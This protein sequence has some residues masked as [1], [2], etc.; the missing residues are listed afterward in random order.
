MNTKDFLA[1]FRQKRCQSRLKS[2][3]MYF[4]WF[5]IDY[6]QCYRE[7]LQRKRVRFAELFLK[8]FPTMEVSASHSFYYPDSR[9]PD[10][11]YQAA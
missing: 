6:A 8:R 4:D 1:S 11:L 2:I 3:Y 5:S 9:Y 10:S 7:R